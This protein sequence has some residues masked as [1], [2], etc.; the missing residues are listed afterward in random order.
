MARPEIRFGRF[1]LRPETRELCERGRPLRIGERA[2]DILLALVEAGG[3]PLSRDALFDRA[4]PGRA[5]LDDNLKVQVMA[6]RRLLGQD[7]IVTVPGQGYRLGLPVQDDDA[8]AAAGVPALFGRE[9]DLTRIAAQLLPGRVLSVVGPGGIGKTRLAQAAAA[10]AAASGAFADGSA[11]VELAPLPEARLLPGTVARALGMP[12]GSGE[13]ALLAALRPLSLLLVLDNAEHLLDAVAS[14]VGSLREA[15]PGVAVLVTSQEPLG[16][17]P[18]AVVRLDG[19]SPDA[20]AALFEARARAADPGFASSG[21]DAEAL[22]R[23][24]RRLDGIPLAL[25]L[26]AA[27]VPLLGVQGVERKLGEALALLSRGARGAPPRQQTLRAA[28]QWSH[29]LLDDAQK[30]VFRRL[31]VFSGSFAPETAEQV[32]VDGALDRWAVLDALQS[33]AEKSLLQRLADA[34]APGPRL[35]L[36]ETARL[37]AAERLDESGETQARRRRHAEAI[38]ALF[39]AADERY[40]ATPALAWL[41][42]LLPELPNLRAA[43]EWALGVDGDEVL[44]IRLCG[45]AGGFWAMTGQHAESGPPLKRLAARVDADE[46]VPLRARALFWLAIAN[47]GADYSFSWAETADACERAVALAREGGFAVLLHRALGHS[48]SLAHRLGRPIDPAAVAD[49]MRSIEGD[50]WLTLQRRSRRTT[51]SFAV[52]LRGDWERYGELER[53]ELK[54]LRHAGDEYRSWFA[55]HRVALS[56]MAQGRAEAA[57]A[58]MQPAVEGIRRAGLLRHCWQQVALLAVAMIE[59]GHAPAAP[60]REAVRLMRG[61]GAMTWSACHLG[62][63]LAQQGRH[64]DAARLIGWATRRLAERGEAA[65]EQ[66]ERARAR[67]LAAITAVAGDLRSAEW[68]AEGERWNDDDAAQAL[69]S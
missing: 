35:R 33:L 66:G 60:V 67:A 62:E 13:S 18:E 10:A 16:L 64:A 14:F 38:A 63:W 47:R 4:W 65:T 15:A 39:E 29:A 43:V 25:E 51:E 27:R 21:D 50:D 19:L 41:D 22:A 5:V 30:T 44:A 2:F 34:A 49:E 46:R 20:S 36:L 42:A 40:T 57:V 9:D 24:C 58:T 54:L 11:F 28:L 26:A 6:L 32:A 48:V 55:A 61:A 68:Q 12:P 31:A 7:A 53:Q 23:I 69:L 1:E 3:R 8:A 17:A 59:A 56:E 45:A 37:F 52:M